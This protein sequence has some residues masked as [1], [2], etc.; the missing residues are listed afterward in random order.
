MSR[1]LM[2]T[3]AIQHADG[4]QEKILRAKALS[5]RFGTTVITENEAEC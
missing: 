5:Y 2:R 1:K 4:T 3:V